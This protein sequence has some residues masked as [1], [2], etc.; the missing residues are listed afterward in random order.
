MSAVN[1]S[2]EPAKRIREKVRK[3]LH[4]AVGPRESNIENRTRRSK[5][6]RI[7]VIVSRNYPITDY[8][9]LLHDNNNQSDYNYNFLHCKN[10]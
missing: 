8:F 4:Q 7:G 6:K 5:I 1:I 2:V 10:N 9:K 3:L